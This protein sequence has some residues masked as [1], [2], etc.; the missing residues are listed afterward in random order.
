MCRQSNVSNGIHTADKKTSPSVCPIVTLKQGQLYMKTHMKPVFWKT[1]MGYSVRSTKEGDQEGQKEWQVKSILF[2]FIQERKEG[3]KERKDTYLVNWRSLASMLRC[4]MHILVRAEPISL[5]APG[6]IK[7]PG[8]YH[9]THTH[10]HT[11]TYRCYQRVSLHIQHRRPFFVPQ[12]PHKAV[13]NIYI[14]ALSVPCKVSAGKSVVFFK[15]M[16]N[17]QAL[18]SF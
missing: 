8:S 16:I 12:K 13:I 10:S 5:V 2:Y 17:Y 9:D 3:W 11:H 14:T 4:L 18:V 15:L 6:N 7:Q 1:Q